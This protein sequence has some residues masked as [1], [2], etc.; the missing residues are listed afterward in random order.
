MNLLFSSRLHK[1]CVVAAI[2]CLFASAAQLSFAQP[3]SHDAVAGDPMLKAMQ[4][5]LDR[6]KAL[7]VLPG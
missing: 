2:A 7:L 4:A 3:E 1:F 5:E 6:E